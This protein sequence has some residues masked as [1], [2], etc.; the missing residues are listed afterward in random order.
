MDGNGFKLNKMT[1]YI[2]NSGGFR[3]KPDLAK[4]FFA[5]MVKGLG[6]TPH[7]L[8]CC[9][10]QAR[11]DWETKFVTDKETVVNLFPVGVQP[12]LEI[13]F[14]EKFKEQVKSSD[15]IYIHG[16]D[17]HL[18]Q[19][20]LR[21]FDIPQIWDGKVV[22]TSSA[23]SHALSKYFWTCD[24]REA[25]EGLGILPIKFLA[26][27]ESSYG[28]HDPRGPIDWQKGYEE[29]KVYKDSE[30]PIYALKEGEYVIIEQ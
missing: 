13:A 9:F 26:H 27:Y 16:G 8:V 29:L 17:D 20:W 24:W 23:S 3:D 19:Y 2:L 15:V 18:V 22:A 14:P 12:I 30:L 4:K 6:D 28:A 5:E 1:K 7:I 25:M 21:K 11:E 10:A